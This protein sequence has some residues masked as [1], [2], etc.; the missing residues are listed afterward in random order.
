VGSE[1]GRWKWTDFHP[2]NQTLLNGESM[3]H[4]L[5]GQNRSR[6]VAHDLMHVDQNAPG[7]LRVEGH[8]LHVRTNLAP[9]LRPVGADLFRS[10][11]KTAFERSGPL[12]IGSHENKGSV[13]VSGVEGR[14]GCAEQLG[15]WCWLVWHKR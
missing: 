9:L 13:D 3:P 10:T 7:F 6:Q 5:I 12:H 14:V 11:D 1:G 4:V 15:F 8:W 2:L